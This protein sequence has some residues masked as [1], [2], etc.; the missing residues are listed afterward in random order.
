[1]S[2]RPHALALAAVLAAAGCGGGGHPGT[3]GG[4]STATTAEVLF[5]RNCG[6]CHHLAAAGTEGGV[7]VDLDKARPGRA[8][9]LQAI[10][11]GPGSMPENL[12]TGADAKAVA[13]YVA[14]VAGG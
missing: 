12:L 10:A 1:V 13:A 11:D 14:R 5:V 6:A 9:V 8:A 2:A 4:G 3:T 7:G